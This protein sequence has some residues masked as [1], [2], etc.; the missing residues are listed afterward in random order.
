MVVAFDTMVDDL[1]TGAEEFADFGCFGV[2]GH[3]AGVVGVGFVDV[4]YCREA[5]LR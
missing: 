3:G 5:I 4:C 2:V 1:L